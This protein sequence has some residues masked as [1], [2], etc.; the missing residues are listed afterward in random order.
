MLIQS[1]PEQDIRYNTAF[2]LLQWLQKT[3][4]QPM[5]W[6]PLSWW[7]GWK[8]RRN[9]VKQIQ[10][11]TLTLYI[12]VK[13]ENLKLT[14]R[15][16][17]NDTSNRA[18]FYFWVRLPCKINQ[19]CIRVLPDKYKTCLWQILKWSGSCT[20]FGSK[21]YNIGMKDAVPLLHTL[22][23]STHRLQ[24]FQFRSQTPLQKGIPAEG[25]IL[26][27]V[28]DKLREG[29]A[30]VS[31]LSALI[32]HKFFVCF[33]YGYST[34]EWSLLYIRSALRKTRGESHSPPRWRILTSEVKV[35][36]ILAYFKWIN[37]SIAQKKLRFHLPQTEILFILNRASVW[38]KY[39][40]YWIRYY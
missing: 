40:L 33:A 10:W 29:G 17:W 38:S 34:C 32:L 35:D 15:M 28:S 30:V 26:Q 37:R 36:G 31:A 3:V 24:P 1:T 39:R 25:T 6:L 7:W 13:T 5:L 11:L 22:L 16:V 14:I 18:F 19:T 8:K 20:T 27:L 21:M 12:A 23:Q 4:W 9:S 2:Y